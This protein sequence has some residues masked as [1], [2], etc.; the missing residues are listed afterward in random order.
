M[1]N[2]S[3]NGLIGNVDNFDELEIKSVQ[4]NTDTTDESDYIEVKGTYQSRRANVLQTA[5]LDYLR[6]L[7]YG[8]KLLTAAEEIQLAKRIKQG[9]EAAR[10][11]MVQANLRLVINIAKRYA[12][13]GANFMDLVQEGNVGLL[14][15]V[16]KFDPTKGCRFSTYATWWIKQ[17]I[18][19]AFSGHDRP[20]RL[21]AHVLDQ[22]AKYKRALVTLQDELDRTPTILELA[23]KLDVSEKKVRQLA[24]VSRKTIS[25]ELELGGDSEGQSQTLLDTLVSEDDSPEE[26]LGRQTAMKNL[27]QALNEHLDEKER[28]ILYLRYGFKDHPEEKTLKT[29]SKTTNLDQTSTKKMT[30][31]RIGKLYG[32]TRECI[33]QTEIKAIQK[34]RDADC[35]QTI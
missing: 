23:E 22:L 34:L 17:H 12:G 35:M 21:P 29:G 14:K 25:L 1:N 18:Y 33:R 8:P 30:L 6:R 24:R 2:A 31:E 16:D 20:I 3:W 15:A 7:N 4:A 19:E 28:N 27:F 26:V 5:G 10:S 9:D 13:R 32:V 11:Q